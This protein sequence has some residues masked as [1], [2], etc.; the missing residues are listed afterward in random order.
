MDKETD[1]ISPE[2]QITP[3]QLL[4]EKRESLGLSI[5]QVAERLRLRSTIV[6][7]LEADNFDIDKVA[8]FTR[9]YVRSYAKLVGVDEQLI[10]SS[11]DQFSGF[12]KTDTLDM[13][14]FSRKTSKRQHNNR[15][16]L[17]TFCIIV[18]VIGISSVWWYQN[19]QLDSLRP[20]GV[21]ESDNG[22]V[23]PAA[24]KNDTPS[25]FQSIKSGNEN[26]AAPADNVVQK[27]VEDEI[28]PENISSADKS[29]EHSEISDSGVAFEKNEAISEKSKVSTVSETKSEVAAAP[30][31][32]VTTLANN[33][34]SLKAQLSMKFE[35]D[36]WVRVQDANGNTLAVGLKKAG[37]HFNLKGETPFSIVLGA[38]E[39]VS[40]T[41]A[42]E[43]VDLSRY[44]SGKVAR[45]TLP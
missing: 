45:F 16:N 43:P 41:F 29:A 32:S 4:K 23:S 3:G 44:T 1:A 26:S 5:A 37:H 30:E 33:S 31:K 19:Q 14:S 9:G 10:L 42:G 15:I 7:S 18:V 17:L 28:A 6:E 38:P 25:E 2:I 8:T 11:F 39:G 13:K 22:S 20:T 36:C 27:K 40:I 35:K 21:S 34:Q 24:D 12:E